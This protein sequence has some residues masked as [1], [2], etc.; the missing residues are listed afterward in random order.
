M[1]KKGNY[2][3][4]WPRPMVA[5]DIAVFSFRHGRPQVLLIKRAKPPFKGQWAL[6]GG[7]VDIDEELIDAAARELAEETGLTGVTLRQLRTFGNVGRDPRGRC[8][9]VVFTGVAPNTPVKG[10]D[11]AEQ[12][13]W[14]DLQKLPARLA[15]DHD[16]VLACAVA[17]LKR[18]RAY[19]QHCTNKPKAKASL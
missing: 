4:N 1:A 9:S 11:D 16:Q 8:I 2:V 12:A 5:V 7:F 19:R 6:P 10:A 3:Y 18:T 13:R 14:F 17:R 15:F